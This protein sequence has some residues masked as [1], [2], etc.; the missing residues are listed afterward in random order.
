MPAPDGYAAFIADPLWATGAAWF[1]PVRARYRATHEGREPSPT[2][3]GHGFFG[4]WYEGRTLAT[5]PGWTDPAPPAPPPPDPPTGGIPGGRLR[6]SGTFF[7]DRGPVL[8][9]MCHYGEAFSA[10]TR[11][12]DAVRAELD[13][14]AR[15]GYDGIRF[16]DNLGWYTYWNGRAVTWRDFHNQDG[17]LVLKTVD[18]YPRLE[19]FLLECKARGLRVAHSRGDCQ[20]HP[21]AETVAH[22]DRVLAIYRRIG[23]EVCAL[24][25]GNNEDWQNGDYGPT[26]LRAI[27]AEAD[28]AGIIT[29]TS[30]PQAGEERADL[31]RYTFGD[32]Y[33]VHGYRGGTATDRLRHIF[34]LGY[35]FP[36]RRN[37][38]QGEPIGPG[39]SVNTTE[40]VEEL[41]LL[42]GMAWLARQAWTYMSGPGV[43]WT[44]PIAAAPGFAVLDQIRLDLADLE[45][46]D[47]GTWPT[48]V[49]GGRSAAAL[50]AADGYHD[51]ASGANPNGPNRI[52]QAIASDGR[53][54]AVIH[55]NGGGVRRV[56]NRSG[57]ALDVTVITPGATGHAVGRVAAGGAFSVNYRV[58]RLLVGIPT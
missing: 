48:L 39:S 19:A 51:P 12:P 22:A 5:I 33:Y 26:G 32:L 23:L 21:H 3:I 47:V 8:P 44:S 1:E 54:V 15:A 46:A 11:R 35:H 36:T 7:D 55:G 37:G 50:V 4:L 18:Y 43:K 9:L 16:W 49:H 40:D 57:R 25:E 52:D 45:V 27:V 24:F 28:R 20:D 30:A 34:S 10:Y 14:I 13:R 17:A 31:E 38:W 2:A 56:R 53:V 29:A 58:G 6:L 41:G 42:A